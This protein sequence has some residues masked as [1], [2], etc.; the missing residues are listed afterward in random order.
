MLLGAAAAAHHNQSEG[1]SGMR[2][3]SPTPWLGGA[4]GDS[5]IRIHGG[6]HPCDGE[7]Q[8]KIIPSSHILLTL[9]VQYAD[10]L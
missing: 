5:G 3:L 2:V 9:V 6:M 4:G 1:L 10:Y 8:G 7:G